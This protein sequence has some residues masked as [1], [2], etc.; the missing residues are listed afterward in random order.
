MKIDPA[1]WFNLAQT[2]RELGLK[3]R[4]VAE[5]IK[6]GKL[7][8]QKYRQPGRAGADSNLFDPREVAELRA[9]LEAAKMKP[10]PATLPVVISNSRA[11]TVGPRVDKDDTSNTAFALMEAQY[12]EALRHDKY[13]TLTEASRLTKLSQEEIRT[14]LKDVVRR[15][16]GNSNV[17]PREA[18]EGL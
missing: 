10:A 12:R 3:P 18:V 4:T 16:A 9:A 17:Y 2:A 7:H 13:L 11:V 6:R 8:P 14:R 5:W 1:T 15:G